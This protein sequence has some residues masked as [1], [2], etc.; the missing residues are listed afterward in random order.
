MLALK[1][2]KARQSPRWAGEFETSFDTKS[3]FIATQLNSTPLDV[4]L[5]SVVSL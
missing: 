5:S 1:V 3:P 4:E 2:S